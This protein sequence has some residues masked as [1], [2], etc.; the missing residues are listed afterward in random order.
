MI[1]YVDDAEVPQPRH[2]PFSCDGGEAYPGTSRVRVQAM[3]AD[4]QSADLRQ[5]LEPHWAEVTS[6]TVLRGLSGAAADFQ[7]SFCSGCRYTLSLLDYTDSARLKVK[8]R[9]SGQDRLNTVII[10]TDG[11]AK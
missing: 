7:S 8:Y 6:R 5:M 1:D 9:L 4:Q 10:K 3:D 2:L 11:R